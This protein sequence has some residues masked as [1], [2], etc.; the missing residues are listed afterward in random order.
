MGGEDDYSTY[1]IAINRIQDFEFETSPK[2]AYPAWSEHI[3][4][5][6][7]NFPQYVYPITPDP[8]ARE[9][10]VAAWKAYFEANKPANDGSELWQ[11]WNSW[12]DWV[13]WILENTPEESYLLPQQVV[14]DVDTIE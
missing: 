10:R 14:E 4:W 1:Q 5:A 12:A 9:A 11:K 6:E 7:I 8:A 13:V 2:E 3:K